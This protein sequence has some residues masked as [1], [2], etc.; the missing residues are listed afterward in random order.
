MIPLPFALGSLCLGVLVYEAIRRPNDPYARLRAPVV[1]A[2]GATLLAYGINWASFP[3]PS[4]IT[5]TA[6]LL[7][8]AGALLMTP[9]RGDGQ[10]ASPSN[11]DSDFPKYRALMLIAVVLLLAWDLYFITDRLLSHGWP[12]GLAQ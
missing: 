1:G 3:Q 10:L 9:G 2:W 12:E 11:S 7:T 5:L 6:L 4:A 8:C